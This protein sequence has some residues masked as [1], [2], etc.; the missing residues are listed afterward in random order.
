[1]HRHIFTPE[2]KRHLLGLRERLGYVKN[3]HQANI[4]RS[5]RTTRQTVHNVIFSDEPSPNSEYSSRIWEELE[6][7]L[8]DPRVE[9]EYRQTKKVADALR[10]GKEVT[11]SALTENWRMLNRKLRRLGVRYT[12][13]YKR[14]WPNKY[15]LTP[16]K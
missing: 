14:G 2:Q 16:L 9:T 5:L 13:Q 8:S 11:V 7:A 6:K 3:T 1:M 12:V 4:A 10:A 15:F